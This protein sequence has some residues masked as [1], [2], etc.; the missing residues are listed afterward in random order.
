MTSTF[1]VIGTQ[2]IL[3]DGE[4]DINN[5]PRVVSAMVPKEIS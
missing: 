5:R 4:Q 2:A 1:R 3:F